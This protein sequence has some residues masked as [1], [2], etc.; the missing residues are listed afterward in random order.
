MVSNLLWTQ[1]NVVE[2]RQI[3][4]GSSLASFGPMGV[5]NGDANLPSENNRVRTSRVRRAPRSTGAVRRRSSE[6]DCR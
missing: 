5:R 4:L 3:P 6:K 1:L 2:T